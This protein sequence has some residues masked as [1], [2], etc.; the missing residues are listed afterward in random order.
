VEMSTA[1]FDLVARYPSGF[2]LR[3]VIVE[4]LI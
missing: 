4:L 2:V 1:D 3:L